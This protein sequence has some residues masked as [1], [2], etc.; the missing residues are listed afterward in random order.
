MKNTTS[1]ED[2]FA[3]QYGKQGTTARDAFELQTQ[4]FAAKEQERIILLPEQIEMLRMAQD[5]IANGRLISDE[6]LKA[7]DPEWLK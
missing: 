5:H 3:N 6:D 7:S 1:F 2:H 4:K